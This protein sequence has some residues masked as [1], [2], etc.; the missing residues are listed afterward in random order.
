VDP[1]TSDGQG[2][3]VSGIGLYSVQAGGSE[4]PRE[5]ESPKS[6]VV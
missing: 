6:L 2:H 1:A 4:I 3:A 5:K